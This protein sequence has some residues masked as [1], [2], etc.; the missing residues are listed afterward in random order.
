MVRHRWAGRVGPLALVVR[1]GEVIVSGLV[2]DRVRRQML[3]SSRR[4]VRRSL[5]RRSAGWL[6]QE[7]VTYEFL[8]SDERVRMLRG[9][10]GREIM[11]SD[12]WM[13]RALRNALAFRESGRPR[14]WRCDFCGRNLVPISGRTAVLRCGCCQGR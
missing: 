8:T 9:P 12:V 7:I 14:V 13:L 10:L 1:E 5:A 11:A 4:E 2:T 6:R 3:C